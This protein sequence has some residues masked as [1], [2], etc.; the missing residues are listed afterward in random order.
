MCSVL[1]LPI[2]AVYTIR[3]ADGSFQGYITVGIPLDGVSSWSSA[4]H[5]PFHGTPIPNEYATVHGV[6]DSIIQ[7]LSTHKNVNVD[8]MNYGPRMQVD[9][10]CVAL[11]TYTLVQV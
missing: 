6:A 5:T 1:N 3:I 10:M 2:V 7:F 11:A 4:V 8:D 9:Q